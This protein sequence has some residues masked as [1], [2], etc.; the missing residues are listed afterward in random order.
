MVL[1]RD[2]LESEIKKLNLSDLEIIIPESEEEIID[3]I[4]DVNIILWNPYIVKKYLHLADNLVWLQSIFAWVDVLV[5]EDLRSDYILTNVKETYG[6]EMS[7][8]VFTY[9]LM[10]KKQVREN[11]EYQK[12]KNWNQYAYPSLQRETISIM[13]TWSIWKEIAR[14]AKAFWMKTIWLRTKDEA[15][16]YFDE[17]YT[18][19]NIQNFCSQADY[20]VSVLP[21][22]NFTKNIINKTTLSYMKKTSVFINVWRWDNVNED[23]LVECLKNKS[24]SF[25]ILDVFKE[26]PLPKEHIF[27][28]LDNIIITPHVSWYIENSDRIVE[29]FWD[30]YKKFV[31]WEPLDYIIDFKRGY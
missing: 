28:T 19:D 1:N 10:L 24:I 26:E 6:K 9:I 18:F 22:T 16:E 4:K 23:D 17:I 7:E 3:N 31:K 25:A 15:V 27:W 5:S 8:Y 21:N 13:W 12:N 2:S 20:V 14:V 29:I 30:N 11:I